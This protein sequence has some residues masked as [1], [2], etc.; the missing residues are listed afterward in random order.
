MKE[1]SR[2][3]ACSELGARVRQS[4]RMKHF[5]NEDS[6]IKAKWQII[7]CNS[8]GTKTN[9]SSVIVMMEYLEKK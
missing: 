2:K 7:R 1:G 8:M 3:R 5:G 6:R 4:R 9:Y